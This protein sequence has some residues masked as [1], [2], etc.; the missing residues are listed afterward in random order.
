MLHG[1]GGG[2]LVHVVHQDVLHLQL[3]A[4][5]H[6]GKLVLAPEQGQNLHLRNTR[7]RDT[8]VSPRWLELYLRFC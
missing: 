5:Y 3:L 8:A 7:G 1:E 4:L 2:L 6:W